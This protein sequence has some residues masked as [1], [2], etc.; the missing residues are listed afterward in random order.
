MGAFFRAG[1]PSKCPVGHFFCLSAPSH[2]WSSTSTTS[3]RIALS[4]ILLCVS[5]LC[6]DRGREGCARVEMPC[7]AF[8][9][10]SPCFG[11]KFGLSPNNEMCQISPKIR[12]ISFE[13][14]LKNRLL[15]PFSDIQRAA[16]LITVYMW[17]FLAV[18]GLIPMRC[19][20]FG[21]KFGLSPNNEMCR[22]LG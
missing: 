21:P 17:P 11:P 22:I 5:R 19:G 15:A 2:K 10:L 18:W 3:C 1:Q 13:I 14:G 7:R 20:E 16:C 6:V 12:P 8:F 4:G 9:C